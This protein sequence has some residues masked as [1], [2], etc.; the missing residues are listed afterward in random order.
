MPE[1]V[2]FGSL[3][4]VPL[5]LAFLMNTLVEWA[6]LSRERHLELAVAKSVKTIII[7]AL[8]ALY[9]LMIAEAITFPWG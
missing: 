2:S 3:A 7:P 5:A 6:L 4:G 1:L 9:A 8:I